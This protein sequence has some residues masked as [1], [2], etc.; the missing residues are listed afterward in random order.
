I[1]GIIST[2][3]G[4]FR[5]RSL[6]TLAV[7]KKENMFYRNDRHKIDKILSKLDTSKKTGIFEK[8]LI[9]FKEFG[10][11]IHA[12]FKYKYFV[13]VFGETFLVH[14]FQF[15]LLILKLFGKKIVM[16]YCGDDARLYIEEMN[17]NPYFRILISDGAYDPQILIQRDRKNRAKLRWQSKFVDLCFGGEG[18]YAYITKFYDSNKIS[19]YIPARI[20]DISG[21]KPVYPPVGKQLKIVHI[22]SNKVIKGT[23]YILKAIEKLKNKGYDFEFILP[24]K[25]IS[26]DEVLKLLKDA[27]IVIDQVLL[28]SFGKFAVEAMAHGK[29]VITYIRPDVEAIMKGFYDEIPPLINANVDN[30]VDVIETVLKMSPEKMKEYGMKGRKFVEKYCASDT[31]AKYVLEELRKL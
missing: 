11:F 25:K 9:L 23:K 31:V 19:K 1:S 14:P 30:L 18:I 12:L 13:F 24:N 15:D 3:N 10:I 28:G 17:K 27:D 2:L 16:I 21:I 20:V 6:K 4:E 29:I 8:F 26:N 22:P 5:K 7:L